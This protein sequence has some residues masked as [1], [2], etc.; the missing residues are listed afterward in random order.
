MF[1]EHA[2]KNSVKKPT[3]NKSQKKGSAFI[4]DEALAKKAVSYQTDGNTNN[5]IRNVAED[6]IHYSR[7]VA[8]LN[9]KK[10]L[11]WLEIGILLASITITIINVFNPQNKIFVDITVI[12][13]ITSLLLVAFSIL[14][15]FTSVFLIRYK[16]YHSY[17][18]H[19]DNYFNINRRR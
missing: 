5:P 4:I 2:V 11:K 15:F 8:E 14:Q 6:T 12:F 16:A 3:Q 13:A 1:V 17:Q 19:V 18:K 7:T 10:S 9:I